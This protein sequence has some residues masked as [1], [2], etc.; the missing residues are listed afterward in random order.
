MIKL[1]L[2]Y[3]KSKEAL[4]KNTGLEN[5]HKIIFYFERAL[6]SKEEILKQ[7]ETVM[8]C[9]KIWMVPNDLNFIF[10]FK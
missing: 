10:P 6:E 9:L 5:I 4:S 7:V 2:S 1:F 8:N 3:L